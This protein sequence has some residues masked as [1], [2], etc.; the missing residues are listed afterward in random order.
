MFGPC[1]VVRIEYKNPDGFLE[2]NES[3]FDSK[4]HKLYEPPKQKKEDQDKDQDK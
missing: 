2:I 4:K 3:D 1:P